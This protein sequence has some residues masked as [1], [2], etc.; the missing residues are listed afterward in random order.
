[1]QQTGQGAV[2]DRARPTTDGPVPGGRPGQLNAG[3]RAE[4][5][6]AAAAGV[7][8]L[9]IGAGI[10]GAGCALD[11]A[12]R[13][14]S[15][16]LVDAGDI[17]VG[18][19]SRSG[20]VLHGGLRYLE[21][22]NF[23]L[24]Y[25]AIVERDLQVKVIAPHLAQPEPFLYP[26]TKHWE[27]PYAGAGITLY[28]IFGLRGNAVP[29]QRHF[30]RRG[31]VRHAPSLDPA[32][33]TGAIQYADVRMD[34]ARHTLA[35]AR[36]A[37]ANGAHVIP[38]AAVVDFLHTGDRITGAVVRD[39][40]T[41][42]THEIRAR[43]VINAAGAWSDDLQQLAG[44]NTFAVQ[45]AKGVHLLLRKEAIDSDTGILARASDSVIIARRW[46]DYWLVGTTDTPWTG[47]KG[48]PVAEVEDVEYLL[49][50][51]NHF[52]ARKVT[53]DDVLGVYAGVRPLLKPVGVD[54]E[55]TSALSRDHSIV[56]GPDGLITIVGG[57]YTTYRLMAEDTVDTAVATTDFGRRVPGSVTRATPLVGAQGW[58]ALQNRMPLLARDH[59]LTEHTMQRLLTRY[60]NEVSDVLALG[61]VDASWVHPVK[62]WAGYLPAE[63]VYGVR[64]EG[65]MTLKDLLVRR[66]HLA[67]EL[68]DGA[69]SVAPAIAALV[70]PLLGWDEAET[71]RQIAGHEAEVAADRAALE[72]VRAGV[73]GAVTAEPT[74]AERDRA[75]T[76]A[77]SPSPGA[78]A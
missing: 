9:V 48:A 54:G 10:T 38:R 3:Q 51:L 16:A 55:T 57:K 30:T 1:M 6:A 73:G 14:L 21:Q 36:T 56:P 35:V 67:I 78:P 77:G 61:A 46:W 34:D 29:K 20:K 50:E 76:D 7:D 75:D 2:G 43:V 23:A 25:H 63:I 11:A 70:A 49:R 18:T 19:S 39:G 26:L 13:G 8:V 41:D 17:A 12:S 64:A 42:R 28:D 45:P 33:V 69:V 66:T 32:V 27:R 37:A 58:A 68:P 15:V 53:T 72:A 24:V 31:A 71:A 40:V 5:L 62:E 59:H 47:D 52:L 60:G 65:A 22:Y 4:S 44:A 74:A